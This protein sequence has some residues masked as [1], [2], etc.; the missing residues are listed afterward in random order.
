[1]EDNTR[2]ITE[3]REKV[4][5]ENEKLVQEIQRLESKGYSITLNEIK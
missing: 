4:L 2:K 5:T 3:I 1:M